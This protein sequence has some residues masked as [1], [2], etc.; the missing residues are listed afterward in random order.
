MTTMISLE[1]KNGN[2]NHL[3]V[4]EVPT[5]TATSSTHKGG[6]PQWDL[7]PQET[8]YGLLPITTSEEALGGEGESNPQA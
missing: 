3:L 5:T 4:A 1:V 8:P 6:V 2:Y 7:R